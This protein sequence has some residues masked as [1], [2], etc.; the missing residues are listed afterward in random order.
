VRSRILSY[1]CVTI[2][3]PLIT[4]MSYSQLTTL[5][6]CRHLFVNRLNNYTEVLVKPVLLM[7]FIIQRANTVKFHGLREKC[8][9]LF[10]YIDL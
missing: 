7:F 2:Q 8:F 9:E 5:S 10:V 6:I 4:H 3:V 1:N